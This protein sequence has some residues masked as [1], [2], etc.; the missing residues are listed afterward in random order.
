MARLRKSHRKTTVPKSEQ[1]PRQTAKF[2]SV[3]D[4][5]SA[6]PEAKSVVVA[7]AQKADQVTQSESKADAKLRRRAKKPKKEV[8]GP[9]PKGGPLIT[10]PIATEVATVND[11]PAPTNAEAEEPQVRK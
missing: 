11:A 10:P 8:K 9:Q 2:R 4:V 7:A 1:A 3:A 6:L 5:I